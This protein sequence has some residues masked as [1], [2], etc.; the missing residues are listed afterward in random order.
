MELDEEGDPLFDFFLEDGED[1]IGR[2]GYGV[3]SYFSLIYTMMLIFAL[4]TVF[5]IPVIMNNM[6]WIGYDGETQ[7]SWTAQTTLGNLGQSEARCTTLKL[8]GDSASIGCNA[9][10]IT[11]IAQFGVYAK[12]S[13]A[14]KAS[15][16]SAKDVEISTGFSCDAISSQDH[17]FYTNK[18]APCIGK[19]S[20][21]MDSIHDELPLGSQS[22]IGGDCVL[23]KT[24][25][26][27]IQYFCQVGEEELYE[28]RTQALYAGCISMFSCLVLLS[29]LKYR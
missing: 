1:P 14:D 22:I 19:Q 23:E 28:K 20:C 18:L 16:C 7:L 21:V 11:A 26:L 8:V 6:N 24:T 5:F 4:I 29:V 17:V 13:D 9:G 3:V 25:T 27:Y 12:N 15:L 2:L 10:K